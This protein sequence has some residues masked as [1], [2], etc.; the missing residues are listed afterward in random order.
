MRFLKY[1]IRISQR[2]GEWWCI[3]FRPFTDCDYS[4]SLSRKKD[5]I[6]IIIIIVVIVVIIIIIV[7][8][9]RTIITILYTGVRA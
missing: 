4:F 2:D 1:V 9:I 8:I 6:I 5:I 7:I 3:W